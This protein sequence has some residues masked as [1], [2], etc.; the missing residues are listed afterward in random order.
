MSH[1]FK[2][3]NS[4]SHT[5]KFNSVSHNFEK[6]QFCESYFWKI[7]TLSGFFF[8]LK[9]KFNS[10][11]K[12]NFDSLS[13]NFFRKNLWVMF[14]K[15]FN[16]FSRKRKRVKFF[17]AHFQKE[18]NSLSHLFKKEFNSLSDIF[19]KGFKSLRHIQEIKRFN[20]LRHIQ[21][22]KRFNSQ[23]ISI[24]WVGFQNSILWGFF[25]FWWKTLSLEKK[26]SI[27]LN[28]KFSKKFKYL[29][30]VKKKVQFVDVKKVQV[31]ESW[32]KKKEQFFESNWEKIFN[33]LSH[34]FNKKIQSF[35]WY[36]RRVQFFQFFEG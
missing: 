24:L 21:E 33:S 9:K 30:H 8:F 19:E 26:G 16:S 18:L 28:Q 10:R 23:K 1:I 32:K 35:E 20:S 14:I 4:L 17:E 13:H 7:S 25:F 11:F 22:I 2:R 5:Q 6:L 3:F 31:F 27:S 15:K 34:I 36:P 29:S 12:E